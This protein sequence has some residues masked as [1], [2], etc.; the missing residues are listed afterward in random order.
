MATSGNGN[1]AER[2]R[3]SFASLLAYYTERDSTGSADIQIGV[4]AGTVPSDEQAEEFRKELA[5]ALKSQEIL[6]QLGDRE[7]NA[8][9]SAANSSRLKRAKNKQGGTSQA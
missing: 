1:D 5:E 2:V 9:L 8:M 7:K 3:D 4:A 6:N